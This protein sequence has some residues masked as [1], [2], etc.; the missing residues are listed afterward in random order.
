MEKI[1]LLPMPGHIDALSTDVLNDD[2]C[3]TGVLSA[4]RAP[5]P[6]VT[7]AIIPAYNEER[8]IAS[9]VHS[10]RPYV[11][12]VV[13]VD[14]GSS[15]RSAD[16]AEAAGARVV[17][18]PQNAGK[19]AALNAGFRA[20]RQFCPDVVIC[21]DGDAQHDPAEIPT[22][23]KPVL[24]GH[25]DVVI[26]SRFLSVKSAIPKWRQAGQHTLTGVTNALSG[27]Q[28]TDSQ[29]GY[30]AFSPT[31][32]E[33]LK[34]K[35]TGLSL[36]SEMQFL[37]ERSGLR[38]SE[39]PISVR[40]TDGNKR[41]PVVHGLQVLDAMLSLVAR[42]RPLLFISLPGI[43]ISCVGL[44]LG[45]YV[46]LHMQQTGELLT[47]TTM[48]TVLFTI[49]GLLLAMSGVMLHSLGHFTGR[50]REEIKDLVEARDA[51]LAAVSVVPPA[52]TVQTA[53]AGNAS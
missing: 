20:A 6:R 51:P 7:V 23:I 17:R 48:L 49:G 11:D 38:V 5:Q 27:V 45:I 15:D 9:V 43:L 41:N 1:E 16:L 21:L 40:Y 10:T 12:H 47:G 18:Q 32:L 13:V 3:S 37:F 36:E 22:L 26:G 52:Q 29:S 8:F 35:S 53:Q 2:V 14:D 33:A 46:T 19:A 44:L 30:R 24:E 4:A 42:R 28:I 39:V 34:F 50:L 31:A 25:A